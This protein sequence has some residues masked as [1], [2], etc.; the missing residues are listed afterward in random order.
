MSIALESW[1]SSKEQGVAE[2]VHGYLVDI[3]EQKNCPI[4]FLSE[5]YSSLKKTI[6]QFFCSKISTKYPCTGSATPCSFELNHDSKAI[7]IL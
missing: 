7:D 5:E 3:L 4:V 1:L 6:G 2:P